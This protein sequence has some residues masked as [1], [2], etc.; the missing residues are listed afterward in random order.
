MFLIRFALILLIIFFIIR[1]FSRYMLRSYV[2]NMKRNY[3]NQQDQQNNK[4]EGDVTINTKQSKEK[5]IDSDE[6]DYVDYEEIE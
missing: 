2:N 5:K 6:G 1:I 4:K 3:E